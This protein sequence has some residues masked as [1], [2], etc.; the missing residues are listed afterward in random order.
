[1]IITVA[2]V[3]F[4]ILFSANNQLDVAFKFEFMLDN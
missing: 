1:M 4:H 3:H 2:Q